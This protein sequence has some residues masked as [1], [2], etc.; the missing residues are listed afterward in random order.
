MVG[1][2][3][4]FFNS[5]F[6][7]TIS[8][9]LLLMVCVTIIT[10]ILER[11]TNVLKY[12]ANLSSGLVAGVLLGVIT[13]LPEF[14]TCLTSVIS[15]KT[16]SIGSGDIIGSNMFDL[17]VMAVCLLSCVWLFVKAKANKVNLQALVC[18]GIGTIFTFFAFLVDNG[19]TG[20]FHGESPLVWHG[21]NF[22]SIFIL[23][24][25]IVAAYLLAKGDKEEKASIKNGQI[26]IQPTAKSKF[27]SLKLPVITILIVIVAVTLVVA[28][29]FLT[30]SST[31]LIQ[32]HW[33]MKEGFGGALLLGVVTSLPEIVCCINLCLHKEYNMVIDTMVG[34]CAF[35]LSILSISNI[36]LACLPEQGPMYDW[37][38]DNV[39]QLTIC[40]IIIILC[41]I[42]L[43][44][45][46]KK[47]K[48]KFSQKQT[49][50]WNISLLSLVSISYIIF[51][52]LGFVLQ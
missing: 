37:N 51:I 16:G 25:Y 46:S 35:N 9:Y 7:A 24:S 44:L 39:L 30:Y 47:I 10:T 52:V 49:L 43:I 17:F 13:S 32:H 20:I 2:I 15:S 14:V 50:G 26:Q 11:L 45:N 29:V 27:N 38:K 41:V 1:S 23:A 48:I 33:E 40:M 3:I 36:A 21:F 8:I 12:K 19:P 4:D 6:A 31:S 34:S 22:F 18:V 5:N 28:S 42:Y